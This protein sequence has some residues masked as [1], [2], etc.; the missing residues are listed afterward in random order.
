MGQFANYLEEEL[1]QVFERVAKWSHTLPMKDGDVDLESMGL[2]LEELSS[3]AKLETSIPS[4]E[5]VLETFLN[6]QEC[7]R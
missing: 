2:T 5:E 3:L 7:P 4:M 6:E 1:L